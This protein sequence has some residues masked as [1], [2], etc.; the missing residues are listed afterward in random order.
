MAV[1]KGAGSLI[2]SPEGQVA[3]C[4]WG[5]PGMASAGMGDVLTGVIAGLLGQGL[6]PW[7]AACLGVALHAQA[8]DVAA[9]G[10][11]AGTLASDLFDPLRKLRN[12][13]AGHD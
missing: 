7:R 3:V 10:G 9:V 8:G 2:A 4:P 1:L 5:N 6:D 12:A 11:Q 13:R